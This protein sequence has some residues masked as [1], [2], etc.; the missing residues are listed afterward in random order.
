MMVIRRSAKQSKVWGAR[1]K[2]FGGESIDKVC[3]GMKG[4]DPIARR[5]TSLKQEA[6]DDVV[7]CADHSLCAAVLGGGVGA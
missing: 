6:A 1:S 2:S 5:K 3:G 7:C 4:L